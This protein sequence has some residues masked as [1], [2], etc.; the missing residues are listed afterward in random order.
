MKFPEVTEK[1]D[2]DQLDFWPP[3]A[4]SRD[5]R[6]AAPW[7][8]MTWHSLV[9]RVYQKCIWDKSCLRRKT[10]GSGHPLPPQSI[11]SSLC[12]KL[13]CQKFYSSA[14]AVEVNGNPPH[15]AL[16][17]VETLTG[18]E[19]YVNVNTPE[20]LIDLTWDL[21]RLCLFVCLTKIFLNWW[22]GL[23]IPPLKT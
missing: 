20:I 19:K 11:L 9:S 10:W 4:D 8:R 13:D 15:P 21:P 6:P 23:S 12:N 1:K 14:A 5:T 7:A 18:F 16:L 2:G 3:Q 17:A 22:P